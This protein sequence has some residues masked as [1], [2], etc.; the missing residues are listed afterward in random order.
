MLSEY[1]FD[2]F[3]EPVWHVAEGEV[4]PGACCDY[5]TPVAEC[6]EAFFAV[7]AARP[8]IAYAAEWYVFIGN[9]HYDIID[10]S[11]SGRSSADYF[12]S[13]ALFSEVV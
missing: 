4:E 13:I 9:M 1:L 8:G 7:I 11:S 3:E 6:L 12:P 10:A 5:R 2:K